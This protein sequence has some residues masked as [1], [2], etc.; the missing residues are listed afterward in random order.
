MLDMISV[1]MR[2]IGWIS[3]VSGSILFLLI[4]A[5]GNNLFNSVILFGVALS[6][7]IWGILILA[8]GETIP[9]IVDIEKIFEQAIRQYRQSIQGQDS[10]LINSRR[11]LCVPLP[12]LEI[13]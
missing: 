13:S 9:V 10:D 1:V 3:I 7:C 5:V 8:A 4:L 2:V 12:M 6:I 11:L